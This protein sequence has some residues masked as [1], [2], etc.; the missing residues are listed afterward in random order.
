MRLP[1]EKLSELER[2]LREGYQAL[3]RE[4]SALA[5]EMNVVRAVEE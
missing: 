3:Q 2:A 1:V 4:D 5:R